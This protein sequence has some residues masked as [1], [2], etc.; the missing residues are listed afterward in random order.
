MKQIFAQNLKV[1]DTLWTG[2]VVT[3]ITLIGDACKVC[4]AN[5]QRHV[6]MK[7]LAKLAIVGIED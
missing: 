4:M 7:T 2:D 3:S 6:H 1:G 5:E